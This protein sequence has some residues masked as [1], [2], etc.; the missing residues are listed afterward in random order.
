MGIFK[1]RRD[2]IAPESEEPKKNVAIGE[3]ELV[4]ANQ[5]LKRYKEGKANLEAKLIENE[6]YWKLRQWRVRGKEKKDFTP[7]TAWLWSCIE[8]CHSDAMDSYPTCNFRARAGDDNAE[9]DMLSSIAPVIL[10][11]AD[12][13]ETYDK[14]VRDT[15]KHGTGVYGVFWDSKA[16]GGLGNVAIKR[17]DLLNL[18]WEPGVTDIQ[19]SSNVFHTE[20]VNNSIL[21]QR[22]PELAG[23][24][25]GKSFTVS[26]Y[27]YDDNVDTTDK[28]I[29]V[30][31]Y[32]HTEYNGKIQLQYCKYVGTHVLYSTENQ[33]EPP[34]AETTDAATGMTVRVPVGES[35]RDRGHYDHGKYPFVVQPL[36]P[37]EGTICGYGLTDIGRDTQDEI[38]SLNRAITKNALV[39]AT[40]RWFIKGNANIN[41]EQYA[42][43]N[44]DFIRVEGNLGEE[45]IRRVD[46]DNLSGNYITIL[47]S[48]VE[49]L[50]Y[51]TANSDVMNG[52][53]PSGVTSASGIAAL[54]EAGGKQARKRNK[55]FH[56]QY[57]EV[58]YLVVELIR[59]FYDVPRQFRITGG[60]VMPVKQYVRYSNANLKGQQMIDENGKVIGIRVP[61]FDIE[62]TTEKANP[63]KKMEMNELALNFYG[64]GFFNPQ[65][66]DQVIPCLQMMDFDGKDEVLA[67]VAQNGTLL[68]MLNQYQSIA[69]GLAQKYEPQTAEMLSQA[70]LGQGGQA[71][72]AP[73]SEEIELEEGEHPFVERSRAAARA[74]TQEG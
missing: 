71:L 20:L 45:G 56:R 25:N 16:D 24:L 42:D 40:P 44:Q 58:I 38:D 61:E 33:A 64:Q 46:V 31:W 14:V 57:R 55:S 35:P 68:K 17:I 32:Y 62:V 11:Y 6:E 5:I 59:Q 66:A 22:Y 54:Q 43:M 70:I 73:S 50:K 26:K 69:L 48:K 19:A 18:F 49:E 4:R 72:P 63:Y 23:K 30:D 2:D 53:T 37:V 52:A 10:E 39:S 67:K 47:Q 65:L 28:S 9:A 34:M 12:F 29:V 36:F 3:A 27:L 15:L 41:Q 8:S 7:A 21:E 1:K 60:E 74:S 51:V 13:E